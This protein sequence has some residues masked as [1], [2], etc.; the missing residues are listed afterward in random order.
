MNFV[1]LVVQNLRN[2]ACTEW[3]TVQKACFISNCMCVLSFVWL[4]LKTIF[5]SSLWN[6]SALSHYSPQQSQILICRRCK[7]ATF[8]VAW[9]DWL[10]RFV[11]VVPSPKPLEVLVFFHLGCLVKHF[12]FISEFLH[13]PLQQSM[14][15]SHFSRS[16]CTT[17][18]FG[19]PHFAIGVQ[20]I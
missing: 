14:F 18:Q 1:V 6:S 16:F 9:L 15:F 8:A 12:I 17:V 20:S 7:S 2:M 4:K 5:V 13:T 10:P 3:T 19:A 11:S